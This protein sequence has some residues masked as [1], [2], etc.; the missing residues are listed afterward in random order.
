MIHPQDLLELRASGQG[1]PK[2]LVL[3]DYLLGCIAANQLRSGD[4]LPTEQVLAES[5][6]V[7]QHRAASL[8]GSGRAGADST[9]PRP[10]HLRLR[11]AVQPHAV[12][13]LRPLPREPPRASNPSCLR[14]T[15]SGSLP[16]WSA[17]WRSS[18]CRPCCV[19]LRNRPRPRRG[20]VV[21]CST[22]E[23]VG[24]QA[25]VLLQL[26]DRGIGGVALWPTVGEDTPAYH[27][28]QLQQQGVPV[29][30]CHRPVEGGASSLG[31][32]VL[33]RDRQASG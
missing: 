1:A 13:R 5:L 18:T 7:A 29:V 28:R 12:R 30:L 23:D 17:S 10:R 9:R 16:W 24:Q 14:P 31:L 2:Y 15:N 33:C 6:G 25:D 22:N 26:L 20:Q 8:G 11:S 27:V 3:K 21:I 19:A 32:G 4:L